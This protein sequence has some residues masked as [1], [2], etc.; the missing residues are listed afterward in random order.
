MSHHVIFRAKAGRCSTL[1]NADLLLLDSGAQYQ[2]GTTG[3][4]MC[5]ELSI[6]LLDIFFPFPYVILCLQRVLSFFWADITRTIHMGTPSNY[7]VRYKYMR[8]M[9]GI[10]FWCFLVQFRLRICL[11]WLTFQHSLF[12]IVISFHSTEGDVYPS[13]EGPHCLGFADFSPR[14]PGLFIGHP[15]Q[16]VSVECGQEL[17]AW[18]ARVWCIDIY[19]FC[20]FPS[21]KYFSLVLMKAFHSQQGCIHTF[22]YALNSFFSNK[23]HGS[24]GGCGT[25]R[26]RRPPAH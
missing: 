15:G 23:R 14:Y 26:T 25:E 9:I 12:F 11:L 8:F 19:L 5:L 22:I 24:R 18:Y 7:Q 16:A 17:S 20:I 13:A 1:T 3:N 21:R 6:F 2:D 10:H 4:W